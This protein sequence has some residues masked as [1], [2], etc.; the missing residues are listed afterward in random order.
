MESSRLLS[1]IRQTA[2]ESLLCAGVRFLLML[3]K[4]FMITV[5]IDRET[6]LGCKLLCK[7]YRE[8]ESVVES[9]CALAGDYGFF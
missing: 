9:E 8:A 4:R 5:H 2:F 3:F 7:F 1:G 6:L